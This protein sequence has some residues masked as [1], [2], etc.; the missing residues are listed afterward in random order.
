MNVFYEED[1][2]FKAG[3]VLADNATSLQ[4]ESTHGKRSKIKATSILIRF[5]EPAISGFMEAAQKLA[6]EID[7]DFLW[8]CTPGE[9]FAFDALSEEYFG[10]AASPLQS[11]SVL[12]R[13]HN[14]PMHFYKKGR[15]KY[16]AAPPEALKAALAS[17]EKKRK[18]AEL[19]ANFTS[20][21][22]NFQ[23][24]QEFAPVL[25]RL[26]YDPDKNSVE[27]K[28]LMAACDETGLA[29]HRLLEKCG[30]LPS[31]H[32]Y[33]LN[34]FLFEHFPHGIPVCE[35]AGTAE[36]PDLPEGKAVAFSIDDASTTEIDDAFS[37]AHLPEGILRIGIHIAAPALGIPMDSGADLHALKMLSTIYIPG[38][39]FTMLPENG[40]DGFTL[41]EGKACPVVSL[42]L[43]VDP[44]REHEIVASNSRIELI[45]IA[46]NLRHDAIEPHFSEGVASDCPF[47]SELNILLNFANRLEYLRGKS[48]SVNQVDY[49][50]N[51]ENGIITISERKRGSPLDKIVAEL[52]IHANTEWARQLAEKAILAIYRSKNNGKVRQDTTAAPHQGLGVAQYAW[53][54]SPLRRYIDLIN[55]RQLISLIQGDTPPYAPGSDALLIAMR[56][57]DRAYEIYNDFQRTMERYWSLKW[58]LQENISTLNGTVQRENWVKLDGLPLANRV[59]SLPEMPSGSRVALEIGQV[60]LFDLSFHA[61]FAERI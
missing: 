5:R 3:S 11:A 60:D 53:T 39:K 21:L 22:K 7:P 45:E 10:H 43:E 33:H 27:F 24:P 26:L 2:A 49:N 55:Q 47:A 36:L 46:S 18:L 48:N 56:D 28:A 51:V 9:E 6:E 8:E 37:V 14:S 41:A 50:F 19:Q 1:G 25:S 23:L 40:I 58:L 32:D 20:Q 31:S 30:A 15:G 52:M 35:D 54:T 42:Y 59:P 12:I 13:L 57:F 61:R 34:R 38:Q 29:A 17:V 4:V 16:K 44:A